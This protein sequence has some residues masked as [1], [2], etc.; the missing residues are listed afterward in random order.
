M[1]RMLQTLRRR[2]NGEG[3]F[4]IVEAMISISILAVG[5]FAV[6]QAMI[7]GLSTTGL[8][9]QKLSSR[10]AVDQQMEE[11]RALNYD[12]LVLSDSSPLASSADTTNPDYWVNASAQ[13]YDPD[14][15]GGLAPEPIVRVAG[16]SPALVHYQ[17][18]LLDGATTYE[19]YRYVTWV[20]S[21]QDGTGEASNTD[22]NKD[23]INEGAHDAKR[24]TVVVDSLW[25]PLARKVDH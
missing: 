23:G 11:A 5:A 25:R 9:R 19:V 2:A 16:A 13:T 6:A 22:G 8:S 20:D 24:V 18:P 14:G 10:A 21:P 15:S 7:F 12:N 3:G 4:T 17:N 1:M